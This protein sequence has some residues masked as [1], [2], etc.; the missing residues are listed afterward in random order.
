[1]ICFI[2]FPRNPKKASH[3]LFFKNLAKLYLAA[4]PVGNAP[5]AKLK[6]SKFYIWWRRRLKIPRVRNSYFTK[7]FYLWL[8]SCWGGVRG[9]FTH[10]GVGVEWGEVSYARLGRGHL[11]IAKNSTVEISKIFQLQK[12]ALQRDFLK[13]K[14]FGYFIS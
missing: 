14:F 2:C 7:T 13:L 5:P 10:C 6:I 8:N 9:Y 3:T 1:M 12:I 11:D 4:A